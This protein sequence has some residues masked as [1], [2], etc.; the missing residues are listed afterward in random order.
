VTGQLTPL[1]Q[2]TLFEDLWT[3]VHLDRQGIAEYLSLS[4]RLV[5]SRPSPAIAT[6][7]RRINY[8]SEWLVEEPLQPAFRRW[9][10]QAVRPL[11]HRLGPAPK[12]GEAEEL[13]ELRSAALFTMGNAGRDPEVLREARRLAGLHLSDAVRLH[14]SLVEVTIQLAAIEGDTALYG[15]YL[16]RV[17]GSASPGEQLQYL[18]ALSFFEDPGLQKRTLEYATSSSI[19]TQDAP[20]LIQSLMLRPSASATTWEYLKNNWQE[21][22]RALGIFQGIPG[23]IRSLQYL[24][25]VDSRNEVD[26]FFGTH[27]VDG[28]D[29]VLRRSLESIQRCTAMKSA[30][31]D[32]LAAFLQPK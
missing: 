9:I 4:S 13:Q 22:E 14:S 1:E 8:V 30:Q 5:T 24:C 28:A 25:D 27:P 11:L 10:R 15:Q 19:R 26:Q 16:S 20:T 7:L 32:D 12:A 18:T 3:L 23:V 2:T 29:R 21:V 6:V 31:S 17:T